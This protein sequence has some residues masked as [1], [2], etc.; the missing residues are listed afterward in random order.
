MNAQEIEVLR[1]GTLSY[2]ARLVY[3]L[4]LEPSCSLQEGKVIPDY[5]HIIND[6][7]YYIK[8]N[9]GVFHNSVNLLYQDINNFILELMRASLLALPQGAIDEGYYDG[10]ELILPLKGKTLMSDS[11]KIFK[12]YADW[13]PASNY[14]YL[15]RLSGLGEI[16]FS[17]LDL[18]NYISYWIG[19]NVAR[20][21]HQWTLGF[22]H[23]L[24][25]TK[26]L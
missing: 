8:D 17:A 10:K 21:N 20:N 9:N 14:A 11:G 12:M 23:F 25:R 4:S 1:N 26:K 5:S 13:Q 16:S 24:K 6:L 18:N 2:H 3:T 19:Q 7:A 15:A 22:I